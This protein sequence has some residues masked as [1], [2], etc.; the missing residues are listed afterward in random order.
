MAVFTPVTVAEVNHWLED[1]EIGHA[2]ALEGIESG[3][4][5]SNFFL[6]TTRGEFILTIF[7]KL[8]AG[9]LPF[10]LNLTAHLEQGGVPCPSPTKSR[11]GAVF[12][13]LKAKPAAV[14]RRLS[15]HWEQ[16]PSLAQ[17]AQ[18]GAMLARMHLAGASYDGF[19]PN[20]RGPKWWHETTPHVLPFLS[21]ENQQLLTEELAFQDS[22]RLDALPRGPI[23][24]DLFRDNVLFDGDQLGGFIDFYFAGCDAWLFDVAVCVNDWCIDRETDVGRLDAAQVAAFVNAYASVRPFTLPEHAAWGLMLRAAALRFW[25]S[26]L[27]DFFLPRASALLKPH[28][29]THFERLL[30]LRVE[31][32]ADATLPSLDTAMAAR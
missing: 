23:H 9:E 27:Y 13:L 25:L 6:F 19:Q 21:G 7:E 32:M 22:H 4:E 15:G 31:A 30:K 5:N 2:V 20:P 10:Y 1:F 28:D 29:P 12:K 24:A 3:I 11:D 16:A 26:R 8:R 17:I 14:V 18:V